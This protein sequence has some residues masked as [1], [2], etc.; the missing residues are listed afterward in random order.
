[1]YKIGICDDEKT[2]CS[3]LENII[4][5][6]FKRRGESCDIQVWSTTEALRNDMKLFQPDILFLDIEFPTDNGISVGKY[7]RDVLGNDSMNIVFISHKTN[8]A[9]DLFQVHPYDFLVKPIRKELVCSTLVKILKLEEVQNK[10]FRYSYNKTDYSISYGEI[11]YFSSNNRK[12]LIHKRSGDEVFY[13]GKLSD[14]LEKLPFQFACISKSYIVNMKYIIS[15]KYNNVTLEDKTNLRI[16]QSQRNDFKN[17]IYN[18]NIRG[19]VN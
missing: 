2:T 19:G 17:T 4:D 12:V 7:I 15:W 10:E 9:M 14:I 11:L 16:A 3:E 6:F 5:D 13:Y 1:M 8:Y 18:Y